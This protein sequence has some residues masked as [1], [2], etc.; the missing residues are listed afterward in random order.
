MLKI[1]TTKV[2][3]KIRDALNNGYAVISEQ[4]GARSSKTYNTVLFLIV[5]LL[6]HPS[7]RLSIVRA[8]LP[9]LKGS[10]FRDFQE[11]MIRL[12][13]WNGK[14]Y[15]K[16]E[17]VYKMEN[18]SEV[19]FFSVDNEQK[20]R[21][22]KRDVLFV[23]EANEISYTEWKQLK[24]RTTR[25]C[26]VD[27]NPSFTDEHW[28]NE[29]NKEPST[30]HFVTTYKDNPFLEQVIVNE[31]ESYKDKNPSLWRVYGVG[32]QA[33][34]EGAV[35]PSFE[36]VD[37]LPEHT[38]RRWVGIDLG[39]TH[40]PT[41]IV[42]VVEDNGDLYIDEIVYQTGMVTGDIISVL[43]QFAKDKKIICESA[44]PRMIEEVYRAGLNIHPVKKYAGSVEAG[45]SKI[46]EYKLK[47]TKR[48][49]NVIKELKNYTYMQDKNGKWLN[50]PI[51]CYNHACDAFRYVV[52]EQ[53]MG[54]AK[55]PIDKARLID[56]LY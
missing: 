6:Q 31:I 54:G 29:L 55:K 7:I 14:K 27:Y 34:I 9:S 25:I 13:L 1:Q 47:V 18:G 30:Y 38:R 26:I 35:Y 50:V 46:H 36:V 56:K 3:E 42:E 4:G 52:M 15:N 22:R 51:D 43:R 10:V 41:A 8:T 45:I 49:V 20:L 39:F 21:G 11:L 33:I 17:M 28:L 5:Y 23:N 53:I 44:D 12:Q 16:S 37:N 48:S 19:E 24:M 32:L 2:F 40:D